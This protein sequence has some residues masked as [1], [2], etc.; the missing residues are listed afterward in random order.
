MLYHFNNTRV[1]NGPIFGQ[2][3]VNMPPA[4]QSFVASVVHSN[5]KLVIFCRCFHVWGYVLFGFGFV[6]QFLVCFQDLELSRWWAE[7]WLL[8]L[9]CS[10]DFMYV[11]LHVCVLCPF[12]TCLTCHGLV[13]DCG[14]SWPLLVPLITI[15][16]TGIKPKLKNSALELGLVA[17]KSVVGK[18]PSIKAY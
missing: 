18:F 9:N 6:I 12:L 7:S 14:S 13:C 15:R 2:W 10:L 4:L 5:F 8:Y 3:G 1:I 11:S 16:A 17:R